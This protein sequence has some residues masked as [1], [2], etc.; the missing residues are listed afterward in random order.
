MPTVQDIAGGTTL[1]ATSQNLTLKCTDNIEVTA[2]YFGTTNPNTADK[3][4]T[5]TAADLTALQGSGLTKSVNAA[6][7]YYL[8]CKDAAGNIASKSI[9][10]RKYQVQNVL[11]KIAGTTGTYTSANY[12]NSGSAATYYIKNGTSLTLASIYSI[13]TGAAAGTFKGYTTSAPGTSA[14]SPSTTAPTVATNNTT[15]YYMWFN[16]N[17]YKVTASKPTNGTVK[18]ETVTK[19]NNSVTASTAAAELTVKYGDTV[20][21]TATAS[22][23]YDFS[24]WSGGYISGTTNPTTGAAI[25]AA[26]T[27]TASFLDLTP[28]TGTLTTEL[29]S[30]A[31]VAT[32]NATDNGSGVKESYAW[33]LSNN[34]TCDDTVSFVDVLTTNNYNFNVA[35]MGIHYVCV[36][37]E[38]NAGNKNYISK[39]AQTSYLDYDYLGDYETF[40]A[41]ED[42]YYKVEAWGAQGGSASS[43]VGGTGAYTSGYIYLNQ[44]ENLYVYVGGSGKSTSNAASETAEGG[45]N[46]GG[47]GFN[48]TSTGRYAGSGGGATDIRL[49][50]GTWNNDT[51]LNSRIMVAAGGAGTWYYNASY[52][53]TVVGDGGALFGVTGKGNNNGSTTTAAGGT[54]TAT[55]FGFGANGTTTGYPG[56]GSGYYG[57]NNQNRTAGGGSSFISGYAGVNAITS[58]SDR[59]HKDNIDHYSGKYFIDG[60]MIA[61]NNSGDGKA[62]I[63]YIGSGLSRTN[64]NLNNVKY[65]KDCINGSSKSTANQWVELQAVLNGVN[66]AKGRPVTGTSAQKNATTYAYSYIV[67]GKIDNITSSSGFGVSTAT[68]NQCITVE[69]DDTYD[70]DEIAVWHYY[71]DGRTFNENIT[72]VSANNFDWVEVI[73]VNEPETDNGKRVSTWGF[74]YEGYTITFDANGGSGAPGPI[75]YI[76]ADSGTINLPATVPTTT[77][78]GYGFVG[79]AT[80]PT[81]TTATYLA[82]DAYPKNIAENITLY[83]VWGEA[84]VSF[85]YTGSYK[86]CYGANYNKCETKSNECEMVTSPLWK[87]Y[88][89]TGDSATLTINSVSSNVDVFLVGGGGGGAKPSTGQGSGGG[90][91]GGGGHVSLVSNIA[92]ATGAHSVTI[93]SGGAGATADGGSGSTGGTTSLSG[94]SG[95]TAA[96]GNGAT[97]KKGAAGGSGGGGGSYHTGNPMSCPGYSQ[98]GVN[99]SDGHGGVNLNNS[100]NDLNAGGAGDG[101]PTTEFQ[102]DGALLY[103]GGGNGAL[104][105]YALYTDEKEIFGQTVQNASNSGG[106]SSYQD[107][108]ANRGGGGGGGFVWNY[109]GKYLSKNAG[110]GGSGVVVIRNHS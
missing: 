48:S 9:V 65:I 109:L 47:S 44:N 103:A 68:G 90:G 52:K 81:A 55:N 21:A 27:I 42:G 108:V 22:T 20:K 75:T 97:G 31:V 25:T 104:V 107:G 45:W 86:I 85:H 49:V 12:E 110:S 1:K 106:A 78:S 61:A 63:T 77:V 59:T 5:T 15:V 102:E 28:P 67:D 88:L 62:K 46:G 14:A 82:G 43:I 89:L 7:T 3:I 18:I 51:S 66:I 73:N 54:P 24:E 101:V 87:L 94:C 8:G 80:S 56:G 74:E 6:G 92:L 58:A 34:S 38:D 2:Y 13:P 96:G 71:T 4:T 95:C 99:G 84:T 30:N 57:G 16:R 60:E 19:G 29:A 32:V 26:K 39:I 72:Y 53:T 36:R 11:E 50:N 98:G 64:L 105:F 10:I 17:T 40:T 23:G 83:A 93:G 76:Y 41:F 37:I 91:G 70:L 69:L 100:C 35:E 79:W 33:K